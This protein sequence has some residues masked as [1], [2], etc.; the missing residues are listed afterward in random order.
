MCGLD[1]SNVSIFKV[2]ATAHRWH[3]EIAQVH[4]YKFAHTFTHH[5]TSIPIDS[6]LCIY[7]LQSRTKFWQCDFLGA[8]DELHCKIVVVTQR[9]NKKLS[10]EII[11]RGCF[12]FGLSRTVNWG[13]V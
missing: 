5:H 12:L 4:T 11:V 10:S 13:K 1:V 8:T 6:I 9:T 7:R 3:V 2:R